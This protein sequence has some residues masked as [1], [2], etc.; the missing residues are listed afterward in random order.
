ML[1][2]AYNMGCLKRRDGRLRV[3]TEV[4]NATLYDRTPWAEEDLRLVHVYAKLD[5]MLP[6]IKQVFASERRT[7]KRIKLRP[8]LDPAVNFGANF[9]RSSVTTH[10][11]DDGGGRISAIV[12]SCIL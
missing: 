8:S 7:Y 9:V 6:C 5:E 4:S 12:L 1:R 2:L 3:W 11:F 10:L